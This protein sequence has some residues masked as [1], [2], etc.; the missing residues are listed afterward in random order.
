MKRF[1]IL[2][3]CLMSVVSLA[4]RNGGKET[5]DTSYFMSVYSF[6]TGKQVYSGKY[7]YLSFNLDGYAFVVHSGQRDVYEC[8]RYRKNDGMIFLTSLGTVEKHPWHYSKLKTVP[9]NFDLRITG[10]DNA[11]FSGKYVS[12]KEITCGSFSNLSTTA[13]V[14]GFIAP[15][16]GVYYGYMSARTD[17]LW[18]IDYKNG[19]SAYVDS[20]GVSVKSFSDGD[21]LVGKE[22]SPSSEFVELD[23][24][25]GEKAYVDKKYLR[26]ITS[27][28]ELDDVLYKNANASDAYMEWIASFPVKIRNIETGGYFNGILAGKLAVNFFIPFIIIMVILMFLYKYEDPEYFHPDMKHRISLITLILLTLL[29]VWY[30][31]SLGTD[32]FWM[33]FQPYSLFYAIGG[34][35]GFIILAT[36]QMGLII[37]VETNLL[38]FNRTAPRIPRWLENILGLAAALVGIFFFAAGGSAG[39][40]LC[41]V[42]VF[43]VSLPVSLTA[44]ARSR[45]YAPMLPFYLICYPM[46]YIMFLGYIILYV[47]HG[48]S[49]VKVST[50]GDGDA[51]DTEY[52]KSI[53]GGVEVL[54]KL[55]GDDYM[56]SNGN[57]YHKSGNT[58]YPNGTDNGRILH[59]Y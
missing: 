17:S 1:V 26:R 37:R 18:V 9:E 51:S 43:L 13:H 21:I 10:S 34:F 28:K 11:T 25:G 56:D 5:S 45:K 12:G 42:L 41:F 29:E 40:L 35:F 54:S 4:A 52:G 3:F 57:I 38:V 53:D 8:Y 48:A 58:F 14:P 22:V 16:C 19:L 59:K 24:I 15:L 23:Y 33:I 30:T 50:Y 7:H 2:F 32:A 49:Q 39:A 6:E 20:L 27:V 44:W 31:L 36:L 46:K 47:L 55:S